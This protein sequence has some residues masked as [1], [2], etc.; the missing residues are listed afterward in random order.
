[1]IH[2][3]AVSATSLLQS[4]FAKALESGLSR[5]EVLRR[6]GIHSSAV[7]RALRTGDCR[8]STLQQIAHAAGLKLT[9]VPA[10]DLAEKLIDGRVF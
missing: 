5:A 2:K 6:A 10:D 3:P 1:M 7:S 9:V 4:V 8:V